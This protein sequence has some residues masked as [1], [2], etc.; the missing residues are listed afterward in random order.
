MT[1]QVCEFICK[2]KFLIITRIPYPY[3]KGNVKFLYIC[4]SFAAETFI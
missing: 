3:A 1:S 4:K 2:R